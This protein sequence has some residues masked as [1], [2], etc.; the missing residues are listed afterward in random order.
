M[1]F[2]MPAL[3]G[4]EG[5][6][7]LSRLERRMLP[8]RR[9]ERSLDQ[10]FRFSSRREGNIVSRKIFMLVSSFAALLALVAVSIASP[11]ASLAQSATA[12]ATASGPVA[13]AQPG[14]NVNFG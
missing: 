13:T 10:D 4:V 6:L 1:C 2:T 3:R 14:Q 9:L 7:R 11:M 5:N 8:S 12:A